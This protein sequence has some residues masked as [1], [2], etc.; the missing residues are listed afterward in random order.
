[1]KSP[2][3]SED[4]RWV[5]FVKA[6]DAEVLMKG[7]DA[8]GIPYLKHVFSVY[9]LLFGEACTGCPSK[10]PHYIQQIKN[11][12]TT[13]KM[14]SIKPKFKL[15]SG[16]LLFATNGKGYSEHNITDEIAIELL[17]KNPNRKTL[18]AVLPEDWEKLLEGEAEKTPLEKL[19]DG[20]NKTQL[21]EKAKAL[22]V[23]DVSGNKTE[24]AQAILDAEETA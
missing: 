16:T 7:A 19:V 12:K 17:K 3:S 24:L 8:K 15:K 23:E 21:I 5:E 9:A 1:M 13:T 22:G 14:E 11:L 10:I 18:F 4:S 2:L 20:N 6:T